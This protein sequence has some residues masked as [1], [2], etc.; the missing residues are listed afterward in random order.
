M[1]LIVSFATND[2]HYRKYPDRLRENCERYG[3]SHDI[4]II[5]AWSNKRAHCAN[6]PVFILEM[7][8]KHQE[9]V[10]WIDVDS[11]IMGAIRLPEGIDCGFCDNVYSSRQKNPLQ[12]TGGAMAFG[13]T[14]AARNFLNHWKD[15]CAGG[16]EW[17]H[18]AMDRLASRLIENHRTDIT[19][20][21][22]GNLKLYGASGQD[23]MK[24]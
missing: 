11:V 24:V 7:L 1:T 2:S 19:P 23:E 13:N 17:D 4:H 3:L 21:L 12:V 14:K 9:T 5:E 15:E 6:K 16:L 20:Y 22:R 10:L 8:D 18:D